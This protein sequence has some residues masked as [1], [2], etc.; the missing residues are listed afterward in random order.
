GER[1]A[2]ISIEPGRVRWSIGELGGDGVRWSSAAEV[3]DSLGRDDEVFLTREGLFAA[4]V[5][6]GRASIRLLRSG[7]SMPIAEVEVGPS[8]RVVSL[9]AARGRVVLLSRA[10]EDE[11]RLVGPYRSAE[12]SLIDGSVLYEGPVRRDLPVSP[13]EFRL[14][15]LGLLGL[16]ATALVICLRPA[17]EDRPVVLPEGTALAEPSRRFA[18]SGVDLLIAAVI[19]G[20]LYGVGPIQVLTFQVLLRGDESWQ[21][22][23]MTPV[24]G[25][26]IGT[27]LEATLGGTIGKLL[28]QCRVVSSEPGNRSIGLLRSL[29]RNVVK[30]ALPPV[31]VLAIGDRSGRHRGDAMARAVVVVRVDAEHA[32]DNDG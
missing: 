20:R 18:A 14:L 24:I 15:A 22:I 16:M 21:A 31:A 27:L 10:D 32:S 5:A 8:V 28:S 17:P 23:P 9:P 11:V 30:W 29:T 13:N 2:L 19:A 26:V 7:G 25:C 3:A 1:L 12:V 4:S 6:D